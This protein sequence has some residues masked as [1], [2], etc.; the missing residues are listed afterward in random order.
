MGGRDCVGHSRDGGDYV[1]CSTGGR[2]C[3]GHSRDSRD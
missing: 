2:D 3:V 1:G